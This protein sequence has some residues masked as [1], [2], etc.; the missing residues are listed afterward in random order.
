MTGRWSEARHLGPPPRLIRQDLIISIQRQGDVPPESGQ[1][2]GT[3][4]PVARE[5]GSALM[6]RLADWPVG[7]TP[8][9]DDAA[10]TGSEFPDE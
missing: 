4:A 10:G 5:R 1:S 9:A 7:P 8:S 3:P 2:G 6:F